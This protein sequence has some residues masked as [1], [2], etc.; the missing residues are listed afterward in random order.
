MIEPG[1]RRKN[2]AAA[3][4]L[5]ICA[6]LVILAQLEAQEASKRAWKANWIQ[7]AEDLGAFSASSLANGDELML[8]ERLS[9]IVRRNDVAYAVILDRQGLA[10]FAGS[11]AN[12]GKIFSGPYSKVAMSAQGTIIQEIAER[13]VTE[14]CV[15]AG[16]LV[17]RCGFT[18]K[19]LQAVNDW[20]W[21]GAAVAVLGLGGAG[22]L[23]LR[24]S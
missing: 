5:G 22:L 8:V 23:L 20:L 15:P 14:V 18:M 1:R 7:Q 21:A 9:R 2:R 12:A 11:P 24:I 13:A 10:R 4:V 6:L 19:H 3:L 17:L 16:G